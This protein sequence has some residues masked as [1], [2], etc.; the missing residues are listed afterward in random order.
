MKHRCRWREMALVHWL[1][2]ATVNPRLSLFA[3][4]ERWGEV[5]RF[6]FA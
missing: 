6:F 1:L 5:S 4:I 3:C 2:S